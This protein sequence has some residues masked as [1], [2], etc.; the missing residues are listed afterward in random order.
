VAHAFQLEVRDLVILA[1]A[2]L[3]EPIPSTI[4]RV[5]SALCIPEMA[6]EAMRGQVAGSVAEIEGVGPFIH[7]APPVFET[8]AAI[9]REVLAELAADL[10]ALGRFSLSVARRIGHT[11]PAEAGST[12]ARQEEEDAGERRGSS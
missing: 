2:P 4:K 10:E 9:K 1:E 7:P 3:D 12:Q 11:I 8:D 5:A 6:V